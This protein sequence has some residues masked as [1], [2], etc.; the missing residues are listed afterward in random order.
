[1]TKAFLR[2]LGYISIKWILFY[3]YQFIESSSRS[4]WGNDST[5]M[6]G[7][8]LAIFMLGVLPLIETVLLFFPLQL[9]LGKK[10]LPAILILI[11][12]F[13]LEF[14]IG[15]YITNEHFE[16]W[17]VVKIFL[18]VVLFYLIYRKQ[19]NLWTNK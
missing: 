8:L 9:A 14:F 13:A 1:M 16:V 19:L 10:G 18:S 11:F 7:I 2:F 12:S 4:K 15:W 17:M 5:N 6:D 3:I